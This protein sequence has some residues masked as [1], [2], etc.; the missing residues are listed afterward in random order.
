M[1]MIKMIS[2]NEGMQKISLTRLQMNLVQLNLKE[3]K[4]N[5]DALLDGEE[6]E[7]SLKSRE[8]AQKFILEAK[9]IGVNCTQS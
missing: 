2:W 5:V 9:K 3:A 6:I 8:V 4:D 7:L 1:V